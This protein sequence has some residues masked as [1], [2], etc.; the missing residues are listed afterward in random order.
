MPRSAKQFGEMR[1]TARKKI[2]EAGMSLFAEQGY[3]STS[4][5]MIANKAGIS[6]GLI[7]NYFSGKE[8]LLKSIIFTGVKTLTTGFDPNRDGV[9]THE[10]LLHFLRESFRLV[11]SHPAYWKLYFLMM[12]QVPALDMFSRELSDVIHRYIKMVEAYFR[13]NGYDNPGLEARFLTSLLDG[14]CM[15]FLFQT[16]SYPLDDMEEKIINMYTK[17]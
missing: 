3:H 7:Y 2:L 8:E 6:K 13:E 15:G 17:K 10:E 1:E 5:S 4:I 16:E 11:R 14:I 9:L 12:Y